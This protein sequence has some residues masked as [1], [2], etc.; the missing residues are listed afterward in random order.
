MAGYIPTSVEPTANVIWCHRLVN[1]SEEEAVWVT[2]WISH[3][4]SQ[5]VV[6]VSSDPRFHSGEPLL[7]RVKVRGVLRQVDEVAS[8]EIIL[9]TS[10]IHNLTRPLTEP[11]RAPVSHQND[12]L[13]HCP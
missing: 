1:R 4:L 11:L 13:R 9:V 2:A 6:V 8:P 12:A 5:D 10:Y 3:E 7:N